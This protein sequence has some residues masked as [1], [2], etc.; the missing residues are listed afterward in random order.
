MCLALL[1]N[2]CTNNNDQKSIDVKFRRTVTYGKQSGNE[3][4]IIGHPIAITADKHQNL[5][6]FDYAFKKI[7]KFS[8]TG[9]LI[10]VFGKGEGKG[11]GEFLEPR[12]IEVD[13]TGQLYVSDLANRSITVFDSLG[14]FVSV[15]KTDMRPLFVK[16]L[17]AENIFLNGFPNTY[18]GDLIFKYNL[19]SPEKIIKRF[20]KR[21][22]NEDSF[23]I[24]MSGYANLLVLNKVK[25]LLIHSSFYPYGI[26][27][28]SINGDLMYEL[29]REIPFFKPPFQKR[30]EP[31]Y[32]KALSG[33]ENT[34]MISENILMNILFSAEEGKERLSCY[35]DF[36][37]INEKKFLGSFSEA[38]LGI[39]M[40]RFCYADEQGYFYLYEEE[41]YPRIVKYKVEV[42]SVVNK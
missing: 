2:A 37:N 28:F 8:S 38:E 5:F 32:I 36:W 40:E 24:E 14:N 12:A 33:V 35:I 18:K 41:P 6:V 42:S 22:N 25:K 23:N 9:N 30:K 16:A 21:K 11:P 1:L 26:E 29:K 17:D 4:E 39:K 19:T 3:D 10:S 7:K 15:L 34:F 31:L 27:V 20:G 13:T